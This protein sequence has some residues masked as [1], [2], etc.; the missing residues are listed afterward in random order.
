MID[1]IRLLH[2]DK[3][4]ST[5][6]CLKQMAAKGEKEG[7]CLYAD[8]QTR[9]KGRVGRSFF[10]QGDCAVYLS[11]LLRP[12]LSIED[13]L[14]LTVIAAVAIVESIKECFDKEVSIKWVNDIFYGKKKI[15]GILTEGALADNN[16]RL[17]YA[18]VGIGINLFPF[19]NL[20]KELEAVAGT[21]FLEAESKAF[22][23]DDK[24]NM[25]KSLIDSILKNF[26]GLY[27]DFDKKTFMESYRRHS[28]V[29][30]KRVEYL[31]ASVSTG[32]IDVIDIN[33]KGELV[34]VDEGQIKCFNTGEISIRL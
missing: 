8:F 9:G 7:V 10:S 6:D 1:D 27:G 5:N 16:T 20:P 15:C 4:A 24:I 25:R 11:I 3:V 22:S 30:G 2:K 31:N 33:D 28:M 21:L 17:D 12:K 14:M 29:I 19:D 26:F 13:S 23:Y 18:V 32:F 34:A